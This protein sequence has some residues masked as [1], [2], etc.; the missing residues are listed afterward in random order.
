MSETS[1]WRV[2]SAIGAP[3]ATF[4]PS[5]STVTRSAMAKTSS[6]LW[7]TK[8][9]A[10]PSSRSFARSLK[11]AAVSCSVIEAVGS[12]SSRILAS[13]RQ[14][15]GD[16][17]DLHLRDRQAAHFGARVD[18]GVEQIEIAARLP[19][20]RAV[21]DEAVP[22]RQPLE[23]DVLADAEARDE[24]A[25]LMDGADALAERI[26]RRGEFEPPGRREERGR[27]RAD[28]GR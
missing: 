13:L 8:T 23:Q 26:A 2:M 3:M 6:S 16:L 7:L 25:L 15:L 5:R 4:L 20:D 27:N 11:R 18:A 22:G 19:L 1:A 9:I 21:V 17:D 14:R 28:R 10:T 12:S 24:I